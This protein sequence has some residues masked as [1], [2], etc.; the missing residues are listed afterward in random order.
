MFCG[1]VGVLCPPL[2]VPPGYM[3]R[4]YQSLYRLLLGAS[5]RITP[6]DSGKPTL[7]QVSSSF[8]RPQFLLFIPVL[9][10]QSLQYWKNIKSKNNFET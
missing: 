4:P 2:E 6:I 9:R 1:W 7:S 8:Q 5:P 3:R 10:F